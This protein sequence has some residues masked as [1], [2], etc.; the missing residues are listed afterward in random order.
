MVNGVVSSQSIDLTRCTIEE[1]N[2]VSYLSNDTNIM[3]ILFS[4][5]SEF[6]SN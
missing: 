5:K 2:Y 3:Q 6:Q 4:T 1:T